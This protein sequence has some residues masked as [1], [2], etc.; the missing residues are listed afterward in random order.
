MWVSLYSHLRQ[1]PILDMDAG[2]A[3]Q[4][5]FA[6]F[7]SA[8]VRLGQTVLQ[9]HQHLRILLVLLHLLRGHQHRPDPLSQVLHVRGESS[10]LGQG[11]KERELDL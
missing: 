4:P 1:I 7:R 3:V 5:G 11:Q 2:H 9:V 8:G 10:V 6:Q